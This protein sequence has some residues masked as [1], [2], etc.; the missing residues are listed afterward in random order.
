MPKTVAGLDSHIGRSFQK[1]AGVPTQVKIRT[2][3]GR[4]IVEP[5]KG[6]LGKKLLLDTR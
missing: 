5:P 4:S 6:K 2:G 1:P 3:S